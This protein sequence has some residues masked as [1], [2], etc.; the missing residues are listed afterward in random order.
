MTV[1]G[2]FCQQQQYAASRAAEDKRVALSLFYD[3][4][5]N[6][7]AS[8]G[9]VAAPELERAWKEEVVAEFNVILHLPEDVQHDH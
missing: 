1:M 6:C 9:L 4:A 3:A 8:C 7:L 2:V 5:I